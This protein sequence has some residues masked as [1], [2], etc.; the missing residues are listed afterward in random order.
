MAL[1]G[2]VNMILTIERITNE[3]P[4]ITHLFK[5]PNV[6]DEVENGYGD[7]FPLRE[8]VAF[9]SDRKEI[10]VFA[11]KLWDEA[12]ILSPILPFV[13]VTNVDELSAKLYDKDG[14][15]LVWSK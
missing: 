13:N 12:N 6:G 14:Y 3:C 11:R 5:T 8:Y 2:S 10:H 15:E 7:E 1:F 9:T 4:S